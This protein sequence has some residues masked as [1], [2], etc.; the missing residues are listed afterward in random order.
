MRVMALKIGVIGGSG[1]ENPELLEKS[2]SGSAHRSE[3]ELIAA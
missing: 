1:L 2:C 3:I